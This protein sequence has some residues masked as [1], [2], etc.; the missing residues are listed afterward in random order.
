MQFLYPKFLWALFTLAI[1]VIIHLFNFRKYTTVYFSNVTFLQNIKK[2][3][4]SRSNLKNILILL[5]RMLAL[6]FLVMVFA[7]PYIPNKDNAKVAE[8]PHVVIYIDNSFSM[9]AEGKYGIL[10]ESAKVKAK[11]LTDLYSQNAK[12]LL[13]TNEFI[14]LHQRFVSSE[15]LVEWISQIKS[16]HIVRTQNEVLSKISALLPNSDTSVMHNVF[17]LSD[18]QKNTIQNKDIVLQNNIKLFAIPFANQSQSNLFIDSVWFETP[19]HYKGKQ[20]SLH[21]KIKNITNESFVE[22]PLQLFINDTLKTSVAFNIKKQSTKELTVPFTLWN[23]GS[24]KASVSISDYPITFDNTLHFNFTID[25]KKRVLIITEN[26]L[27]N[28]FKALYKNDENIESVTVDNN[29]IPYNRFSNYQVIILYEPINISSGL[30]NQIHQYIEF[31]GTFIFMPNKKGNIEAYNELFKK[32]KSINFNEYI[33]QKGSIA[34]VDLQNLIFKSVFNDDLKDVRLPEYNGF[35]KLNIQ[36]KSNVNTIFKSESGSA[37]FIQSALGKGQYYISGLSL[38]KKITNLGMHP[39]FVPLFYNIAL[40]SSLPNSLYY[41]IKPGMY[42]KLNCKDANVESFS[43]IEN[44][45]NKELKPKHNL[46]LQN[47]SIYPEANELTAGNY[48]AFFGDKFQDYISF[49]YDRKESILAYYT[50]EQVSDLYRDLG[51]VDISVVNPNN[52]KMAKTI[53]QQ[54]SGKP[55][56]TLFLWFVLMFFISEMLLLRFLK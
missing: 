41:W 19:G 39:L 9:D 42:C 50:M 37:L 34:N 26:D 7:Q 56:S 10:L 18:F 27:Q 38:N 32:L 31:G 17:I 3:T 45:T 29:N 25:D 53:K 22:I 24:F 51:S 33:E 47:I 2:E 13:L 35:F 36:Q 49:N 40:F 44:S 5:S 4:K 28:Y 21:I 1:P 43:I 54:S 20:E 52:N 55:L 12:Y 8:V 16:T 48:S 11:E 15:Q 30:I 23:P 46:T 6:A 14:L